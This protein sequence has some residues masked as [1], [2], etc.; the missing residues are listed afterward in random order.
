MRRVMGGGVGDL[1]E[2][3]VKAENKPEEVRL[4]AIGRKLREVK[5]DLMSLGRALILSQ[6]PSLAAEA[7]ELVRE[8]K[9]AIR[10]GQQKVKAVL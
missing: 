3:A 6:D 2:A 5:A 9:E 8:I 1:H 10:T 7:Q 4:R